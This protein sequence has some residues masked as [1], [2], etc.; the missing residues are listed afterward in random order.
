MFQVSPVK[1]F[2]PIQ[3]IPHS[4]VV[5]YAFKALSDGLPHLT[6]SEFYHKGHFLYRVFLCTAFPTIK[7]NK[8]LLM[9]D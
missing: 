5:L 4:Y 8:T 6:F 3:R 2:L 7:T 1:S 9:V